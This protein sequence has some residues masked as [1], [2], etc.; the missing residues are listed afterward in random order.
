MKSPSHFSVCHVSQLLQS[1]HFH[2][3]NVTS[4]AGQY[5]KCDEPPH[6]RRCKYFACVHDNLAVGV[7]DLS[8]RPAWC[9]CVQL[10]AALILPTSLTALHHA[11]IHI[12]TDDYAWVKGPWDLQMDAALSNQCHPSASLTGRPTALRHICNS[13]D[14]YLCCLIRTK[15][16]RPR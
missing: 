9:F 4:T 10:C 8:M 16:E 14:A 15:L 5:S 11:Y 1:S 6:L 3:L 12:M 2:H 7:P 13:C